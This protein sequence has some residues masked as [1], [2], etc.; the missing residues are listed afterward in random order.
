MKVNPET[1]ARKAQACIAILFF[2]TLIF[3]LS[4]PR[5]QMA[6]AA[7]L[8][9]TTGDDS[10]SGSLREAIDN[11]ADGDVIEFDPR[12]HHGHVDQ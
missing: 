10:G 2:A 6:D 5:A 1:K 11:A 7:T 3:F 4:L 9:I 8:T 12:R